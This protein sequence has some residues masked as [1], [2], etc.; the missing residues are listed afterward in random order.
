MAHN[1]LLLFHSNFIPSSIVQHIDRNSRNF[2]QNV[3]FMAAVAVDQI[4]I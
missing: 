1:I 2:L 4:K 3:Y